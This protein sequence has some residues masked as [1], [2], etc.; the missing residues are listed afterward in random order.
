MSSREH[1]HSSSKV[2]KGCGGFLDN[3]HPRT[4]YCSSCR[5]ATRKERIR[6]K[7]IRN[8]HR[9]REKI[10]ATRQARRM[11]RDNQDACHCGVIHSD[12]RRTYCLT[13]GGIILEYASLEKP[14]RY[15]REE[16]QQRKIRKEQQFCT[17]NLLPER[18]R[19]YCPICGGSISWPNPSLDKSKER[20]PLLTKRLEKPKKPEKPQRKKLSF[21]ERRQKAIAYQHQ[22]Y[23]RVTKPKRERKRQK[24]DC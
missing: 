17:C 3:Y 10:L 9:N 1:Y 23:E 24:D 14:R 15:S 5:D 16:Y 12:K 4:I 2:C 7:A 11:R 18:K 22:Y 20:K 21:E 19:K 13:C 8:Y 6:A